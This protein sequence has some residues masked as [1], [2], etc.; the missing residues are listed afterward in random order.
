MIRSYQI[1]EVAPGFSS[2]TAEIVLIVDIDLLQFSDRTPLPADP[3]LNRWSGNPE[4]KKGR[5]CR[6]PK[7]APKIQRQQKCGC[8]RGDEEELRAES[9]QMRPR[10]QVRHFRG[11]PLQQVTPAG[12]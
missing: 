4:Q 10:R 5:P 2:D 6:F 8:K 1:I 9:V 3:V 7:E 11:L 12:S